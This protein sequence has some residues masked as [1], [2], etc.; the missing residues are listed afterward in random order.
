MGSQGSGRGW[1]P[2]AWLTVALLALAIPVVAVTV[3]RAGDPPEDAKKGLLGKADDIAEKVSAIR[4]LKIKR[5]IER[6]VMNKEQIRARVLERM[7]DEYKPEELAAEEL[8][9]KRLGLLPPSVDYKKL[10]IDILTDEIAGFYDPWERRLYIA[11]WQPAQGMDEGVMAHEIDHALQDQHF[12][13]RSFMKAVR[14]NGDASSARQ[15][16]VEGD[17]MAL[18]VEFMM[19]GTSPWSD[20]RVLRMMSSNMAHSGSSTLGRA[21]LILQV[22]LVFPYTA[23]LEFV[24]YFRKH[25]SWKRIDQIFKKPPL[26]TE[27]ILHPTKYETYERPDDIKPSTPAVLA[28]YTA[29]YDNVSGELGLQVLLRQHGQDTGKAELAAE[30]WGGDRL[31]VYTPAGHDGSP[32]GAVAV[33][34]T[35]WDHPSDAMEFHDS[36]VDAMAA[37]AA[38]PTR[39]GAS[40]T[41]T[42][43]T[44]ADG[45]VYSVERKGDAVVIIVGAA[46]GSAADLRAQVW[47]GWKVHRR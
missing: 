38:G 30:G 10:V 17:G 24:A 16:L 18:M 28:G 2:W 21:P 43:W 47:S 26:A 44:A 9:M 8:A 25:H 39:P 12:D 4:G 15:A 41:Y 6:G 32:R 29:T 7:D 27:H 33:Q 22:G 45:T 36:A 20:E 40:G 35:V 37:F 13:L 19:P 1:P 3:A 34:Y 14:N 46:A 23:G 31:V 11:G 5:S 42:A